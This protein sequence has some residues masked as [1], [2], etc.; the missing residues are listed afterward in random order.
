MT[1]DLVRFVE[2]G[3]LRAVVMCRTMRDGHYAAL[4]LADHLRAA[5]H[6]VLHRRAENR[7]SIDDGACTVEFLPQN[8]EANRLA[9]LSAFTFVQNGCELSREHNHWLCMAS[10]R[11][12]RDQRMMERRM[13]GKMVEEE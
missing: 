10:S 6:K 4:K 1:E 5:E 12:E 3:G 11:Y 7:L 8:M 2:D 9:S 13:L